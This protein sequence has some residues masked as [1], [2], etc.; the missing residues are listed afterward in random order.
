M[1]RTGAL[2]AKEPDVG[3]DHGSGP[4][5][6]VA[7]GD[8]DRPADHKPVASGPGSRRLLSGMSRALV[9]AP[10][11]RLRRSHPSARDGVWVNSAQPPD[12]PETSWPSTV[13][14]P[15]ASESDDLVV[16]TGPPAAD[17]IQSSDVPG[18]GKHGQSLADGAQR[19]KPRQR[20]GKHAAPPTGI[21]S[22]LANR[23]AA[24]R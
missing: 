13:F 9:G 2:T 8:A 23:L 3:S 16:P 18:G 24:R 19:P 17:V 11:D 5:P 6:P 15:F 10:K 7:P 22:R 1:E 20:P 4:L 14:N 21:G 12:D